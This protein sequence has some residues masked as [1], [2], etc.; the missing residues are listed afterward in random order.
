MVGEARGE[1]GR[2]DVG[3]VSMPAVVSDVYARARQGRAK[4]GE[5][6]NHAIPHE[7]RRSHG[8]VIRARH[9][10]PDAAVYTIELEP[11][12]HG[13]VPLDRRWLTSEAKQPVP[14]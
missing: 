9:G 6:S 5:L 12:R 2:R 14:A 1:L 3:E 8:A 4:T 13:H 10:V 7:R 11:G